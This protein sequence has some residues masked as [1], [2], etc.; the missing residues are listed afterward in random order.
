MIVYYIY[1]GVY[2]HIMNASA[3]NCT[4][5]FTASIH[6]FMNIYR[7]SVHMD[8]SQMVWLRE[9]LLQAVKLCWKKETKHADIKHT[10]TDAYV[11][12]KRVVVEIR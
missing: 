9:R 1:I 3:I 12:K 8:T 11:L 7:D 6:R 10:H 2:T 4:Q 5:H